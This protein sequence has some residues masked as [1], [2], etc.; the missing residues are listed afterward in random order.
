MWGG[1]LT[2]NMHSNSSQSPGIS[3]VLGFGHSNL[4]KLTEPELA[5]TLAS[6]AS[7]QGVKA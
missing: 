4:G 5:V 1:V 3:S 2:T 6:S 7:R